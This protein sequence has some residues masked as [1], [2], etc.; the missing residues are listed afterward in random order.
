MT[1][2]VIYP[3]AL[4]DL[5]K[6]KYAHDGLDPEVFY[7]R[8]I[9]ELLEAVLASDSDL[10]ESEI[11]VG[12][13]DRPQTREALTRLERNQYGVFCLD[14]RIVLCGHCPA[15][16]V[17]ACELFLS[18]EEKALANG[19]CEIRTQEEWL[20]E[21][22]LPQA[23]TYRGMSDA[24]F[25]QT[26]FVYG[27]VTGEA[28]AAYEQ[29][30]T[31]SGYTL[32]FENEIE[33]NRFCRYGKDDIFLHL[34]FIPSHRE[35]RVICGRE[36]RMIANPDDWA[37]DEPITDITLTQ[38][39]LDY[40]GGSFG[41]CYIITLAD[42]SYVILDGGQ[43]RVKNGYPK[44]YDYV[45]LY[46][47]LKEMNK[48]P[49]G[50]ILIR[51]WFMTH[52]HAD[53]FHVFYWFC[54]EY[55]KE[56]TLLRYCACQCSD[57]VAFNAKNPEYHTSIGRLAQASEWVG[58]MEIVVLHTGD[59]LELGELRF[60]VLY[61]VDDLY[62]TRLHYF[63]DASF[64]CRMTY[65]GQQ[66]MW[67]GDICETPS[68]LLRTRYS[69]KTLR[70]EIVQLAHHGLNGAE[71]ELY[72]LIDGEILLWS[73]R[74]RLIDDSFVN[75]DA[76]EPHKRLAWHLLNEMNVKLVL[77]HTKNNDTLILPYRMEEGRHIER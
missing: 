76:A 9:A 62:P 27:D 49:D 63:N 61:T 17:K 5:P 50:K 40:S 13:V 60:E 24:C 42:G 18:M 7:A 70:S 19:F 31:E 6:E 22:P 54:R 55:G 38:M 59:V 43:V 23:C 46:T 39:A 52:E 58:G 72:D 37:I 45:R 16:T 71:Q 47:L 67:L 3:S 69:G 30:L 53:H 1:T 74:Y 28:L 34:S 48:R 65:R 77:Q 33:G 29:T 51:A 35:L 36:G 68:R 64:V 56:V 20:V 11:L 4:D 12:E 32:R 44:T 66:T 25:A 8:R 73:L 75:K 2:Y 41:M 10:H 15:G 26:V 57:T 14:G 21:L